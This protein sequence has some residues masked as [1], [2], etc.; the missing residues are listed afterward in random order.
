MGTWGAYRA[1]KV[2]LGCISGAFR[3]H[4]GCIQGANRVYTDLNGCIKDAFRVQIGCAKRT[5][6]GHLGCVQGAF[7]LRLGCTQGPFRVHQGGIQDASGDWSLP[8]NFNCT[9]AT[10]IC[11]FLRNSLRCYCCKR[12]AKESSG[13]RR[14]VRVLFCIGRTP[15]KGG[16]FPVDIFSFTSVAAAS[17]SSVLMD[18]PSSKTNVW[19]LRTN[20][21]TCRYQR[22]DAISNPF[23]KQLRQ[24]LLMSIEYGSVN[25]LFFTAE[26]LLSWLSLFSSS[27]F[28]HLFSYSILVLWSVAALYCSG[29]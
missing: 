9:I 27:T 11:D 13:Q 22:E 1:P 25:T 23:S 7:R 18:S 10:S 21:L 29:W 26:T 14:Q 8:N 5:R 12:R 24:F 28:L 20:K 3:M 2:H 6:P 15:Y 16:T 19:E 17:L 4:L